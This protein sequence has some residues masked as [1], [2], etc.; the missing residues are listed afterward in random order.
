MDETG[1]ARPEFETDLQYTHHDYCLIITDYD[2]L[3]L[4][5]LSDSVK[6]RLL[7]DDHNL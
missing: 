5:L 7:A 2:R 3:R 4:S 1:L 6:H